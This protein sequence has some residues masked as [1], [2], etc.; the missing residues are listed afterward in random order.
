MVLHPGMKL[1]YFRQH[2]WEEEWIEEA[3]SLAR[4]EY[5]SNYENKNSTA[6]ECG[7]ATANEESG[8][9]DF[10]NLSVTASSRA[11][12]MDDYL[13]SPVEN[14]ADPLIWWRNNRFVYPNLSRMA[15]D[16]LSAPGECRCTTSCPILTSPLATST[17]V[18]RVFSQGRHILPFTRN[19]LTGSAFRAHLCLGSWFR[20]GF[21]TIEEVLRDLRANGKRKRVEPVEDKADGGVQVDGGVA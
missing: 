21:I 6:Q 17:A 2:E 14:V 5:T 8:F 7:T 4:K 19:R 3:E 10:A 18:E 1:E 9:F 11:S 20:C 12:E 13:R 15:L 16:F